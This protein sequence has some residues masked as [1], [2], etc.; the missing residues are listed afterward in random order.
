M[1]M[2][3]VRSMKCDV[4][5][6]DAHQNTVTIRPLLTLKVPVDMRMEE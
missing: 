5:G 4:D 6:Y 2:H 3:T 1:Y